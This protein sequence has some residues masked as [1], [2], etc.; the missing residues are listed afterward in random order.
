[1]PHSVSAASEKALRKLL[2]LEMLRLSLLEGV[3][4][5]SEDQVTSSVD[6]KDA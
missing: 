6:E 1:M 3:D 5:S 2:G 4:C